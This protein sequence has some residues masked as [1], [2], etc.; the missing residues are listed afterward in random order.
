MS[1]FERLLVPDNDELPNCRCG[2]EMHV[3]GP[4]P[5]PEKI[6]THIRVYKCH[7]C[8]HEMRL[9]I[10]GADLQPPIKMT[11]MTREYTPEQVKE[12]RDRILELRMRWLRSVEAQLGSQRRSVAV[13]KA[14]PRFNR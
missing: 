12:I 5:S 9:A 6:E 3:A 11:N 2:R 4:Y 7:A 14:S 10:W 8:G 13:S 1:D